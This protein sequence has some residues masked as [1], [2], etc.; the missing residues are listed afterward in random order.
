VFEAIAN[1]D[2]CLN[3]PASLRSELEMPDGP[4][5]VNSNAGAG[6]VQTVGSGLDFDSI[7]LEDLMFFVIS[8]RIDSLDTSVRGFAKQIEN[9]NGLLKETNEWLA[10]ARY[11]SDNLAAGETATMS[12]DMVQFFKDNGIALPDDAT[13]SASGGNK[14]LDEQITECE[15]LLQAVKDTG[16]DADHGCVDQDLPAANVLQANNLGITVYDDG[17]GAGQ[18]WEKGDFENFQQAVELKLAELNAQKTAHDGEVSAAQADVTAAETALAA[19]PDNPELKQA[20]AEAEATLAAL[21]GRPADPSVSTSKTYTKEQWTSIISNIQ[22]FQ[23]GLNTDSQLD[24]IKF[25]SL[26][27]KHSAAVELLSNIVKKLSE[28]LSSLVRNFG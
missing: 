25:Q 21:E 23:E 7:S 28:N 27:S 16:D 26:M 11:N 24:M 6:G 2:R 15:S 17:D 12:A 14:S 5:G 8:G 13:T 19:D 22:G 4:G 18:N 3:P 1:L 10:K 9:R 20:L